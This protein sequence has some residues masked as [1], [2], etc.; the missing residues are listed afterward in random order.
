MPGN[1]G[2]HMPVMLKVRSEAKRKIID[3]EYAKAE[4]A[5]P[6]MEPL[7]HDGWSWKF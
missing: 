7:N 3:E 4:A 2:E 1:P 5:H 6:A